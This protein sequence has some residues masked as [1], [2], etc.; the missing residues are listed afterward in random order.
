MAKHGY[1]A[2]KMAV[3][4]H[5]GIGV[6]RQS[7]AFSN[8]STVDFLLGKLGIDESNPPSLIRG[9]QREKFADQD[10]AP[11]LRKKQSSSWALK[12][13]KLG[14]DYFKVGRHVDAMNEYNKAL[15]I[16]AQNVEALVARGALY[17]TKGSLNKA[18]HDFE[19][20]LEFCPSH[21]NAKKYLC[22]TL[23][24]RG[25]QLEEED[26]LGNAESYYNKALTIDTTFMEAKEALN[27]VRGIMQKSMEKREEPDE[28]EEKAKEKKIET[29]A[30]KLRKL[31]KEEKR[32]KKRKRR[33]SSSSSSS[34][35]DTSYSSSS[36]G[37]KHKKKKR[38]QRHSE[39]SS[40][41]KKRSLNL[42]YHKEECCSPPI[43]TS[44][45][46]LNHCS[47]IPKMMEEHEKLAFS[48]T[49]TNQKVRNRSLSSSSLEFRECIRGRS[50]DSIDSYHST[51]A[52]GSSSS[53][54]TCSE[55][56]SS[57][58]KYKSSRRDSTESYYKKNEDRRRASY[59]GLPE[60]AKGLQHRKSDSYLSKYVSSNAKERR[61]SE[62]TSEPLK[63]NVQSKSGKSSQKD[64]RT[65]E[66]DNR[67]N[68]NSA[69][70]KSMSGNLMNILNQIS[71]FE[72]EKG[73]KQ[74]N[75]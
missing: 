43:D 73:T 74:K 50:E 35:S 36:S 61:S 13:V 67:Q 66:S 57:L 16:D 2:Y 62:S 63:P 42:S 12:C 58:G 54:R 53:S 37:H 18:I 71:E 29:S 28:K 46:F 25:G 19:V 21:R 69:A 65:L 31:L 70:S 34:S 33:T 40:Q 1:H 60:D 6:L 51:K 8:P 26:K 38:R 64:Q 30:E 11:F 44:A 47:E 52:P 75:K 7:L 22:Q 49:S 68:G 4:V 9:L 24:E 41:S 56:S 10:Y 55:A 3:L 5:W 27:K 23:V 32:K 17:A 72:K 45:T 39:C 20:A 15:E 14:V 59:S 48:R